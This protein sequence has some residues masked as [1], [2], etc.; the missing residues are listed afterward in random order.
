MAALVRHWTRRGDCPGSRWT[1]HI[2]LGLL[3]SSLASITVRESCSSNAQVGKSAF[4]VKCSACDGIHVVE[5]KDVVPSLDHEF[6]RLSHHGEQSL[7]GAVEFGVRQLRR[8]FGGMSAVNVV[9]YGDVAM[10]I[11]HVRKLQ[12]ASGIN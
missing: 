3:L 12:R 8:L 11:A 10:N 4:D 2:A 6:Y 1:D 7:C 5:R 9:T